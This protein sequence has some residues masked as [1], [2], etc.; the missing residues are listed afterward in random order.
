MRAGGEHWQNAGGAGAGERM[1]VSARVSLA[2]AVARFN[3]IFW[4]S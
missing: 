2:K 4:P 1:V 3:A